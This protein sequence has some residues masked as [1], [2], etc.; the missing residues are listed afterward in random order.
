MSWKKLH[1]CRDGRLFSVISAIMILHLTC[2][3]LLCS[4]RVVMLLTAAME[5]FFPSPAG[6]WVTSA[7]RKITGCWNTNG[8]EQI[9]SAD[10]G[11]KE[12]TKNILVMRLV[13]FI[14]LLSGFQLERSSMSTNLPCGSRMLLTPPSFT[15]IFRQRLERVWGVVFWTF[16]T[17]THC[18]A[19]PSTVSPT[20][21]TSAATQKQI[22]DVNKLNMI[23]CTQ[24]HWPISAVE[25]FQATRKW[26]NLA[27]VHEWNRFTDV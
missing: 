25:N 22:K 17:C 2:L 7:P 14:V 8:L 26:L 18:V 15:L 19:M 20:R 10:K 3:K 24:L 6:G 13:G 23:K 12:K 16:F 9:H 21:F 27:V 5:G 4:R 1:S 11:N